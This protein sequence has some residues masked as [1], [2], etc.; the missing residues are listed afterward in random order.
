[1]CEK[2]EPPITYRRLTESK[3]KKK[4]FRTTVTSR[5]IF[6]WPALGDVTWD[7]A[8]YAIALRYHA[9]R[10]RLAVLHLDRNANQVG[11]SRGV[12]TLPPD[13]FLAPGIA[14][15]RA[16]SSLIAVQEGDVREPSWSPNPPASR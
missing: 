11:G 14:A 3:K 13:Q 5:E 15:I 6:N 7:G 1:M 12:E 4:K 2:S 16:G 9:A 10:W 8:T